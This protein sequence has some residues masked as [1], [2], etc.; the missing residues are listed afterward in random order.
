[1]LSQWRATVNAERAWAKAEAA[2]AVAAEARALLSQVEIA[3]DM[4]R[5]TA[6]EAAKQ[7]RREHG[8]YVE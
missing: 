8:G 4:G 3:A 5:Q 2:E 6:D 1:M 7:F